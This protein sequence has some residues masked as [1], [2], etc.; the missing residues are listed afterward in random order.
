LKK[1]TQRDKDVEDVQLT[2]AKRRL[3]ILRSL[4]AYVKETEGI[5]E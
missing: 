5:P 4:K 1:L 3:D 2:R